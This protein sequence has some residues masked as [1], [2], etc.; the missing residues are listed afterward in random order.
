MGR[1]LHKHEP[2]LLSEFRGLFP[3]DLARGGVFFDN[4]ELIADEHN[5]HVGLRIFLEL[6]HPLSHALE[7]LLIGHIVNDQGTNRLAVMCRSN[8]L[9][10]LGAGSVPDLRL[11]RAA[12]LERDGLGRKLHTDRRR[13]VLWQLALDISRQ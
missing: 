2:L 10:F 1:R 4:V 3:K 7:R 11:N 12:R 8:G 13:L 9:E 6:V 5:D